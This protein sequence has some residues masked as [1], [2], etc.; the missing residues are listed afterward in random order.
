MESFVRFCTDASIDPRA[1]GSSLRTFLLMYQRNLQHGAAFKALFKDASVDWECRERGLPKLDCAHWIA[2]LRFCDFSRVLR[3]QEPLLAG[4]EKVL[5]RLKLDPSLTCP[6]FLL[7]NMLHITAQQGVER[8]LTE[9]DVPDAYAKSLQFFAQTADMAFDLQQTTIVFCYILNQCVIDEPR[10]LMEIDFIHQREAEQTAV[11]KARTRAQRPRLRS[12]LSAVN[13]AGTEGADSF[14]AWEHMVGFPNV[15]SVEMR[16]K[17]Y[18]LVCQPH[19]PT[20]LAHAPTR[21]S[22]VLDALARCTVA[23][24]EPETLVKVISTLQIKDL[25]FKELD[26]FRNDCLAIVLPKVQLL[27]L[28]RTNVLHLYV[29]AYQAPGVWTDVWVQFAATLSQVLIKEV[30]SFVARTPF[31]AAM[32]VSHLLA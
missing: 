21:D 31:N 1:G 30:E 28:N 4:I 2:V 5:V 24:P 13:R 29:A 10:L 6:I 18:F 3:S 16:R 20:P 22:R 12:K 15:F 23:K 8:L 25:A 11:F 19:I 27:A 9:H 26:S 7:R 14:K 17:L 32:V